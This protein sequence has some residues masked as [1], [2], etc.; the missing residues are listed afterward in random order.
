MFEVDFARGL[1]YQGAR[2]FVIQVHTK[3]LYVKDGLKKVFL[4]KEN[5]R[6][7][8]GKNENIL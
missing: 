4:T 5:S 7:I 2:G 1:A 3:G 6:V 8:G